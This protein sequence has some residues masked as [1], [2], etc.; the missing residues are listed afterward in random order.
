MYAT[1]DVIGGV[2]PVVDPTTGGL[3]AADTDPAGVL[4]VNNVASAAVV[5]VAPTA[6]TGKYT[7]SVTLPEVADGDNLEIW[8]GATVGGVAGGN[9]VWQ[10][11]GCSA[12]PSDL[13]TAEEIDTELSGTHGEGAWDYAGTGAG[14]AE[15]QVLILAAIAEVP[16][17]EEIDT[18]LSGTHGA[19]SWAPLTGT[20]PLS[21]VLTILDEDTAIGVEAARVRIT[22]NGVAKVVDTALYA[23]VLSTALSA[24]TYLLAIEADGYGPYTGDLVI[25]ENG[26]TET[27]ELTP[28]PQPTP[29]TPPFVTGLYTAYEAGAPQ[30]GVTVRLQLLSL[31]AGDYGCVYDRDHSTQTGVGGTCS[32]PGLIPNAVYLAQR[33]AG[34]WRRITI[35]ADDDDDG[36]VDLSSIFGP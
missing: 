7:W 24:G 5:T 27:V 17:A 13:P 22:L 34:P 9:K 31:P 4:H 28:I 23:G 35:P 15:N 36:Y 1:G 8:I 11:D 25:A 16:T 19:G 10:G 2:F 32:L 26:W 18:E 12:R 30:A 6:T 14:T 21:G 20:G 33:N 29:S 3:A